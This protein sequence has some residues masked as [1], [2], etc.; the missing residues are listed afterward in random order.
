MQ[1][2]SLVKRNARRTAV[3][4]R[5]TSSSTTPVSGATSVNSGSAGPAAPGSHTAVVTPRTEISPAARGRRSLACVCDLAETV[6]KASLLSR[7]GT[8]TWP[9][10]RAESTRTPGPDGH[11]KDLTTPAARSAPRAR[12]SASTA[13]PNAQKSLTTCG[14]GAPGS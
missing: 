8:M 1:F 4:P 10:P 2:L 12:S 14:N 9:S 7:L 3:P 5:L 13:K 6:T 11:W